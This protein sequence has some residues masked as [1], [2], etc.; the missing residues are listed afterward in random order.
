MRPEA[1]LR[2]AAMPFTFGRSDELDG[3]WLLGERYRLV[4]GQ[5]TRAS[6]GKRFTIALSRAR[7]SFVTG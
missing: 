5:L 7:P 1:R 2:A 3:R 4:D 6:R